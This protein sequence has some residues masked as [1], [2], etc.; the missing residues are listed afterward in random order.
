MRISQRVIAARSRVIAAN[1]RLI[2]KFSREFVPKTLV[3][4]RFGLVHIGARWLG[5]GAPTND[6]Q[7]RLLKPIGALSALFFCF[8]YLL[9]FLK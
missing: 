9:N 7:I 6:L 2:A 4:Q 8:P 1:S 5:N 3:H